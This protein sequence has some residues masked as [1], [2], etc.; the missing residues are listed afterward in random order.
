MEDFSVCGL[1]GCHFDF[2]LLGLGLKPDWSVCE[3]Y[4]DANRYRELNAQ[5]DCHMH[6]HIHTDNKTKR[7]SYSN[8]NFYT[9]SNRKTDA[10]CIKG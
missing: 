10:I 4:T 1:V 7:N 3:N 2:V 9:D 5:S 8:A 6:K